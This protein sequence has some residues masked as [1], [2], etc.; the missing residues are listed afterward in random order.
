[1]SKA[2]A[3]HPSEKAV[4]TV[5]SIDDVESVDS[6][7]SNE[8][9]EVGLERN[10]SFLSLLGFS[11]GLINSWLGVATQ[12]G[13]VISSGGATIMVW[14]L[15]L[16]AFFATNVA[17][18]LGEMVSAMPDAGGQ[19]YW[20]IKLAPAKYR[21]FLAYLCGNFGYFGSV[22]V[23]ASITSSLATCILASYLFTHPDFV[24]KK[25]HIF[26]LYELLNI[27]ITFFNF[28]SKTL[29]YVTKT[30]LYLSILTFLVTMIVP[31]GCALGDFQSSAFVFKTFDNVMGWST[32]GMSYIVNLVAPIWLFAGI[33]A[34]THMVD[35]L[36]VKKSRVLIPRV[37][38]ATIALGF[39][40]AWLYT[41]ILTFCI[42][43]PDA[44][45][46]AQ[47]PP[48]EIYYQA[49]R[50]KNA[51]LFLMA[52]VILCYFLCNINGHTWQARNCWSF[53]RDNGLPGSRY[54]SQIN[55]TLHMPVNAH[56]FSVFWI[57]VIGCIFLAS[58][59]AFNAII[60]AC[61][62]LLLLSYMV[63][64]ICLLK[65]GRSKALTGPFY[66]GKWGYINNILTLI[67]GIFCLVFLSF[68]YV[69]PVEAGSMNYVSAVYGAIL[70]YIVVY[71]FARG[72]RTFA[73]E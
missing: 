22:F 52:M 3:E 42:Q 9:H 53:S 17:L 1:M 4:G 55:Q 30:A 47:L 23:G 34:A 59:T 67:W 69:L 33:D 72:K 14:G 38:L 43:D 61:I 66:L 11:F 54:W 68:P 41:V 21:R 73:L 7:A 6:N 58:L 51:A 15:V 28:Y 32:S 49:V 12:L 64:T 39:I 57:A 18:T 50:N 71:W 70:V 8:E 36:G 48:L 16:S 10:F 56:L 2:V 46:A 25:W 37:M 29:P 40:T 24:I 31:A 65:Y 62:T 26:L 63:P 5:I 27:F 19:Y 13:I 60:S 44:V 35:D 20:T 45:V